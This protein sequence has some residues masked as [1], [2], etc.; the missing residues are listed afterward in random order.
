MVYGHLDL[1][2]QDRSTSINML[3]AQIIRSDLSETF[4]LLKDM[5]NVDIHKF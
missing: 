4:K 2:Y 3:E 5:D 1:N